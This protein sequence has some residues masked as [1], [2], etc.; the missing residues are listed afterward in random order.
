MCVH[1]CI[2]IYI[3][4]HIVCIYFDTD[5]LDARKETAL[6]TEGL[7]AVHVE[8]FEVCLGRWLWV[9]AVERLKG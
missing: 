9:G 4:T 2:Y 6:S 1:I 3:Y 8:V 7:A 5:T